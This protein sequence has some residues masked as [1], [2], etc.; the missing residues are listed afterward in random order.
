MAGEV[1]LVEVVHTGSATTPL[2]KRRL[3]SNGELLATSRKRQLAVAG[4][5]T[6]TLFTPRGSRAYL[7][8]AYIQ[9]LAI[10][11]SQ[12]FPFVPGCNRRA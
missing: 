6:T 3:W 9:T 10:L 2:S 4:P 8:A 12:G 1:D 5:A 11:D 7:G